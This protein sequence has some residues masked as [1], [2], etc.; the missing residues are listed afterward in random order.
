MNKVC[1]LCVQK[2]SYLKI[3]ISNSTLAYNWEPTYLHI[4]VDPQ[5]DKNQ[6]STKVEWYWFQLTVSPSGKNQI[7]SVECKGLYW[8][9]THIPPSACWKVTKWKW[10]PSRLLL[11]IPPPI[12][13]NTQLHHLNSLHW[14][15]LKKRQGQKIEPHPHPWTLRLSR[16]LISIIIFIITWNMTESVIPQCHANVDVS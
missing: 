6:I 12:S 7:G 8:M 5:W 2:S 11:V 4:P 15:I 16:I 9:E 13:A 10:N 14:L 1:Y 3:N